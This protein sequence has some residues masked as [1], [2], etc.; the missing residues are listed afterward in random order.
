MGFKACVGL[1]FRFQIHNLKFQILDVA[2]KTQT[3]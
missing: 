2:T 3:G 1:S